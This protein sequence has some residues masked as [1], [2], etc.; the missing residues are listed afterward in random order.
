MA[1]AADV[2]MCT[3]VMCTPVRMTATV[4]PIMVM[5]MIVVVVVIPMRLLVMVVMTE[6]G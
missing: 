6:V 2:Y 3:L 1:R 5:K 4:N